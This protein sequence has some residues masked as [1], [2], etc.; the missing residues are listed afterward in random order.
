VQ[1]VVPADRC[2]GN[3]RR[4]RDATRRYTESTVAVERRDGSVVVAVVGENRV[5]PAAAAAAE[6]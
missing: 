2:G 3:R 6:N 1:T 4:V 5:P